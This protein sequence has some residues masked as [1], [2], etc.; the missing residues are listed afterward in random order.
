MSPGTIT[1][2]NKSKQVAVFGAG[3]RDSQNMS[4]SSLTSA[5]NARTSAELRE[6]VDRI[7]EQLKSVEKEVADVLLGLREVWEGDFRR[8]R[9]TEDEWHELDSPEPGDVSDF[10]G[11]A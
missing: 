4:G 6:E 5:S 10:I 1:S 3:T 8:Y 9:E 2:L 11:S 7:Q